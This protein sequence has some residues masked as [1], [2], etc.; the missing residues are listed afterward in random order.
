MNWWNWTLCM[1]KWCSVIDPSRSE[2]YIRTS[3]TSL[4]LLHLDW[5]SQNEIIKWK[6]LTCSGKMSGTVSHTH[7]LRS[8]SI[9]K[10]NLCCAEG[11]LQLFVCVLEPHTTTK[12]WRRTKIRKRDQ[13]VC[14]FMQQTERADSFFFTFCSDVVIRVKMN[15][16]NQIKWYNI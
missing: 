9:T 6:W 16:L 2:Y 10:L 3:H 15:E 5:L 12:L 11:P 8:L 4:K 13:L 14:Y 1:K 7:T